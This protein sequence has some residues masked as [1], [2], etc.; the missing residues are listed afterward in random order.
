MRNTGSSPTANHLVL[1]GTR[2]YLHSYIYTYATDIN[3]FLESITLLCFHVPSIAME[4]LIALPLTTWN[5]ISHQRD[6]DLVHF[7][8]T[9][10][11]YSVC[12]DLVQY[13]LL[14]N[15]KSTP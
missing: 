6:V 14:S 7:V 3:H 10:N 9:L 5:F 12:K 8:G 2:R 11:A 1:K 4:L 13:I 15:I